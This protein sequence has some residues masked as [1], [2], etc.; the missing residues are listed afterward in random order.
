MKNIE[1]INEDNNLN[2]NIRYPIK[3][4]IIIMMKIK[5][6]Q[7]ILPLKDNSNN[8]LMNLQIIIKFYLL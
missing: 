8:Y 6:L 7:H 4:K 5:T 3:M 2:K 1:N